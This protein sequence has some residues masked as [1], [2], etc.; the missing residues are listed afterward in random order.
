MK[1]ED[2]YACNFVEKISS[3]IVLEFWQLAQIFC[4]VINGNE[5]EAL[6]T[7]ELVRAS[8]LED[9]NFYTLLDHMLD[10]NPS[11]ELNTEGLNL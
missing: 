5:E 1:L 6:F 2:E 11:K 7:S 10:E 3:R 4:L 8:G 9:E